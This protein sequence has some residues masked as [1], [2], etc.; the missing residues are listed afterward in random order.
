LI[1]ASYILRFDDVCPT[2]NWRVWESVE[3]V[4]MDADIRPLVAVVPDNRDQGLVH[5][6]A[7]PNFWSRVRAWQAAGW[8]IGMHGYRHQYVTDRAGLVGINRFSEFAGLPEAIQVAK[9]GAARQI[10]FDEGIRADAWVAPGHSFDWTTVKALKA[11]GI[12]TISDGLFRAPNRGPVGELWVPQQLWRLRAR[13]SGLWTVAYHINSW[14]Q[15]DV[16]RFASDIGRF[17][18]SITS[19][20]EGVSLHPERNRQ[21]TDEVYAILSRTALRLKVHAKQFAS[22]S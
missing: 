4:L 14:T 11:A 22:A 6:C 3:R 8:S 7:D 13:P 10:F 20:H 18:A 12:D 15:T 2:M 9:I 1:K 16:R 5:G 21:W 17:R 19:F